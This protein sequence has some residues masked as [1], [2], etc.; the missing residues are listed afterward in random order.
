MIRAQNTRLA[1]L[2]KASGAD[3][4]FDIMFI[5]IRIVEMDRSYRSWIR[6][7]IRMHPTHMSVSREDGETED[8]FLT[9]AYRTLTPEI[10]VSSKRDRQIYSLAGHDP[11]IAR[12]LYNEE[13]VTD[14]MLRA[15]VERA[16][17]L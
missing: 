11:V 8:D 4:P 5:T 17:E 13:A 9:R 3:L 16:S 12:A 7:A 6:T 1:A 10:Q 2:E 15:A 14:E